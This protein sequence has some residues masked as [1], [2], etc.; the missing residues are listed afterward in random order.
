[1]PTDAEIHATLF[2]AIV[3]RHFPVLRQAE[4]NA[5]TARLLGCRN[6]ESQRLGEL[7]KINLE[8]APVRLYPVFLPWALVLAFWESL[9]SVLRIC[10]IPSREMAPPSSLMKSI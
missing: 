2:P 5:L 6:P 7:I 1:M 9:S 4:S 10:L 3:K 8:L